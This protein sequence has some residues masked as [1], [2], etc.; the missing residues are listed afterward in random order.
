MTDSITPVRVL[1][2]D[3][4]ALVRMGF[5]MV[6]D[7]EPGIE[8][9]GEAADGR[10]AVERT[11]TLAPDIV[12]M[13]VRMPGM[14][15]IDA[16]A[17]IVARHPATR[18]IVLTTFDLDEYAFAGLRAGASGFLVK[19]TRPE[20]LMEAIRA[21]ADGDA[22]ISPRVTRRM[23][24][25]LGPTMPATGGAAGTGEG[26]ADPRLRP[27]TARELE[28]LTA[29]AEGLT[30]QEIAGRL[31]LSESTVKTHVGRVLAKLEVRDRVQ[32]V[33]LAYDCGLV[34]PGA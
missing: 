27:L 18:V 26:A 4:Q 19:D 2:V 16:T 8:V 1:I 34:R 31:Y 3:D 17:E 30:N 23:I 12:L 22:A 32:A 21:V 11:G 25:L 10:A 24:E 15:G 5:R 6:L 28:V 13:D 20:H 9:V 33:I 7:A 29:L 14:D